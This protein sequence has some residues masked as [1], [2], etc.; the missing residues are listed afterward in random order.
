MVHFDNHENSMQKLWFWNTYIKMKKLWQNTDNKIKQ[1][2]NLNDVIEE[3]IIIG[4][5]LS[6]IIESIS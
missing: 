4:H 6:I 5:S 1:E 3:Y 2:T